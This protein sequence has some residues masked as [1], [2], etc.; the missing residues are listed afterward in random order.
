M[1]NFWVASL[2]FKI[3]H[4]IPLCNQM[5]AINSF[6]LWTIRIWM[7]NIMWATHDMWNK[8]FL[9]KHGLVTRPIRTSPFLII[10]S[11]PFS[12][13]HLL[14]FP[15][16]LP[17]PTPT[18]FHHYH[19]PHRYLPPSTLIL[20][21]TPTY[22]TSLPLQTINHKPKIHLHNLPQRSN[23]MNRETFQKLNEMNRESYTTA[24]WQTHHYKL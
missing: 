8:K 16:S 11:L 4:F 24:N 23:T 9:T 18:I 7:E 10:P 20:S 14:A 13:T 19:H 15:N 17:S 5:I 3:G 2:M 1:T 22:T 21:P 6:R 12:L